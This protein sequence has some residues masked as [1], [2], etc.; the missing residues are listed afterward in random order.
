MYDVFISYSRKDSKIADRIC[1]ELKKNNITYFIDRKGIAG[2][3]EFP[4]IIVDAIENSKVFLFIGSKNSYASRYVINEVTYMYNVKGKNTILPYMIDNSPLPRSLQ[5]IFGSINYRNIQ[6]HPINT[7]LISDLKS[8]LS[9]TESHEQKPSIDNVTK[10]DKKLDKYIKSKHWI[11]N[12][13]YLLQICILL[14]AYGVFFFFFQK[15][16]IAN[17]PRHLAWWTNLIL[18]TSI[19][20]SVGSTVLL[21]ANKKHA[22]YSICGLDIIQSVCISVIAN[23]VFHKAYDYQS[24]I[25]R[26]FYD[27]G[28]GL[29]NTPFI[30]II[31]VILF[32]TIH[33][34]AIW[35]VLQ[36]KKGSISAW[37][38]LK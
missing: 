7:L 22:F 25:Y 2:G 21:S 5:F 26:C 8:M 14:F 11:V 24:V 4:D 30:Y 17:P 29:A 32:I 28:A 6:E 38:Q 34:A 23:I 15:G 20:L 27:L 3:L 19:L 10:P 37:S 36:I 1:S 35:G 16:F 18:T 31:F 9:L 13:C 12:A 33:I